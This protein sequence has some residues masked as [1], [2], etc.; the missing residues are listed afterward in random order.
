MP[1]NRD[2]LKRFFLV[3]S[4]ALFFVAQMTITVGPFL[5]RS[6]SVE[7]DDA[8]SYIYKA[9][10]FGTCFLQDCRALNNLREQ[11]THPT[12]DLNIAAQQIRQYHRLFVTYQP[13]QSI[14]LN[15]LHATGMTYEGAYLVL[16]VLAKI[17]LCLGIAY[18]L[19]TLFGEL[20][21]ALALLFLTPITYSGA[22]IHT[23]VPSAI[24][25]GPALIFWGMIVSKKVKAVPYFI[26]FVILLST[27]H[28]IGKVYAGT[29]LVLFLLLQYP[30][31][32]RPVRN[33]WVAA[34]GLLALLFFLPYVV[35]QPEFNFDPREFYPGNWS[36][37]D[38]LIASAPTTINL[39]RAWQSAF[40]FKLVG[41][42][43]TL[44]ILAKT[45]FGRNEL[46]KVIFLLFFAQVVLGAIYVV[47]FF[48]ALTFERFWPPF[49]IFFVGLMSFH[50]ALSISEVRQFAK[51]WWS[52][53]SSPNA[54][55]LFSGLLIFLIF[56]GSANYFK[57]YGRHYGLTLENQVD[58]Q[59]FNLD[60]EQPSLVSA[61][62]TV[63]YMDEL[64]LYYYLANGHL[65]GGAI[66]YKVLTP[67]KIGSIS[68]ANF[69]VG[70]NPLV[71]GGVS[72]LKQGEEVRI[73]TQAG[74]PEKITLDLK[75]EAAGALAISWINGEEIQTQR[76]EFDGGTLT[77]NLEPVSGAKE[78]VLESVGET[79]V[80]LQGITI[81]PDQVTHWPWGSDLMVT[82]FK[83]EGEVIEMSF[84]Y[85]TLLQGLPLGIRVISDSAYTVL[86]EVE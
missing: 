1:P 3:A 21:T 73:T 40:G 33:N 45:L 53:R 58:R 43:L 39:V 50:L 65:D 54:R 25:L 83:L 10:Q 42:S 46:H 18:F 5:K 24:A 23:M 55:E 41:T 19:F 77:L 14:A 28:Q 4:F 61:N 64:P 20:P 82:V 30:L 71:N 52:R 85:E 9:E 29:G 6:V 86:A 11:L 68:E 84:A 79:N 8:Y 78:L 2:Q 7:A 72:E 48:N 13:L 63:L 44:V 57:F 35:K 60:P 74:F 66:S 69:L 17:L 49:A 67:D 75:A 56:A 51:A 32:E 16:V 12:D 81:S 15:L 47:P 80:A 22:G 38:G 62:S 37:L 36:Y 34:F 70:T 59:D 27:L 31:R 26:P 76:L